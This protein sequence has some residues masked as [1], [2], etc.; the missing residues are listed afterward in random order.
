MDKFVDVLIK[1]KFLNST[2]VVPTYIKKSLWMLSFCVRLNELENVDKLGLAFPIVN[3]N[4]SLKIPSMCHEHIYVTI[5][6]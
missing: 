4:N 6:A 2:L 5:F 1:Y 3:F